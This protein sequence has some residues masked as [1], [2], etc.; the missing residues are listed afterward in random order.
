M[1]IKTESQLRNTQQKLAEAEKL[2]EETK[3]EPPEEDE[4]VKELT[5]QSLKQTINELKEQITRYRAH[6]KA[7][8]A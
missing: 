7:G 3:R 1:T 4:T 2:Y 5:L 8:K 6:A